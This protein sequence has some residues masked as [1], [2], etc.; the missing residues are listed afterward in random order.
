MDWWENIGGLL[1]L[2]K[3]VF[4]PLE[5]LVIGFCKVLLFILLGERY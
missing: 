2:V 1:G 3:L 4:L 5:L